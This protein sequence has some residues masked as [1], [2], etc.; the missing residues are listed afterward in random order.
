MKK[1]M[2]CLAAVCSAAVAITAA[3]PFFAVS[4]S[5]AESYEMGDVDQ[6]GVVNSADALMIMRHSVGFIQLSDEQAALADVNGDHA[7]NSADALGTLQKALIGT[8]SAAKNALRTAVPSAS[9]QE[10][11][12][13]LCNKERAK[14]GLSEL[15][16]CDE[17]CRAANIRVSELQYRCDHIRPDGNKWSTVINDIGYNY[18]CAGENVAGGIKT[19][20]EVVDEWMNSEGHRENILNP[21][22]TK[23]GVAYKFIENSRFGYY[24]DQLFA[25]VTENVNDESASV[26]ALLEQ[27]NKA[28]AEKGLP[29]LSFDDTLSKIAE[30]RADDVTV[31]MDN[32]RPDGSNWKSL[33]E[34]FKVDYSTLSQLYCAGQQNDSDVI[35]YYTGSGATP[36]FL[37]ASKDYH[38]IGIGHAFVDGDKYGHYWVIILTD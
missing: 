26:H 30:I 24:W 8:A 38:K 2:K 34:Q 5:A 37:D 14:Y 18:L 19:P 6:N 29:A 35:A 12:V 10:Q 13:E 21:D 15:T 20:Q 31:K 36:K 16:L 9:F 23:I 25:G 32:I 11:V 27:I 17:L 3:L 28:R 1:I 7:V 22:F 4:A 33:I